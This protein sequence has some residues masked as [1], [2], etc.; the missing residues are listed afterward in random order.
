MKQRSLPECIHVIYNLYL[1]HLLETETLGAFLIARI[2]QYLQ[3][4]PK[5]LIKSQVYH[6]NIYG[7]K[8]PICGNV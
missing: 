7:K 5:N 8:I 3:L 2:I 4:K 1:F 6:M